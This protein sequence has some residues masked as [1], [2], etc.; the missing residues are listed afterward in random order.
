MESVG[1]QSRYYPPP[2]G[3]GRRHSAS[4]TRVNA[5]TAPGWGSLSWAERRPSTPTPTPTPNPSPAEVG[6]IRLRPAKMPNSGK[7]E[8]GG[9][10]AHRVCGAVLHQAQTNVLQA[11][12]AM[13]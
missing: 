4:K 7:P 5:L 8:F 6:Y 12:A 11:A 1:Q 10:E 13:V 3:E 9:R 2:C